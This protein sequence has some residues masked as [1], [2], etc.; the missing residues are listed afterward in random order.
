[1]VLCRPGNL[2]YESILQVIS[3]FGGEETR[4][5][6]THLTPYLP[7]ISQKGHYL[8]EEI[9]KRLKYLTKKNMLI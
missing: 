1:M 3:A 7:G 6:H 9:K 4:V 8:P 5:E 2:L